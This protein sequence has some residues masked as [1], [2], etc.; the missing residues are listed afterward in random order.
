MNKS[1]T[2]IFN[3]VIILAGVV[4]SVGCETEQKKDESSSS[5]VS[6]NEDFVKNQAK[7]MNES[8]TE[9]TSTHTSK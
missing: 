9:N 8:K 5:I 1:K 2:F 7:L 3:S 6:Y 4:L